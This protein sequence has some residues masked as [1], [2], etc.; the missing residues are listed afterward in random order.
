[1]VVDLP[2]ASML[3]TFMEPEPEQINCRLCGFTMGEAIATPIDSANHTSTKRA[4]RW[5]ERKVC[6]E[7]IIAALF[8]MR[9]VE[10]GE[11]R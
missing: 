3:T 6:M 5:A 10:F 1:V 11:I 2:A 9:P 7:R 8:G 4:M